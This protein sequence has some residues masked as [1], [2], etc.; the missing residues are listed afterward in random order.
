M[1]NH[2]HKQQLENSRQSGIQKIKSLKSL[3]GLLQ[4]HRGQSFNVIKGNQDL[5]LPL[6]QTNKEV[7]EVFSNLADF[8]DYSQLKEAWKTIYNEWKTLDAE[9][10][11]LEGNICIRLHSELILSLLHLVEDLADLL[12]IH[13][14]IGPLFSILQTSEWVGQARAQ[15]SSMLLSSNQCSVERIR[16]SFLKAKLE[17]SLK[18]IK[19]SSD[20]SNT[21]ENLQYFITIIE[22]QLLSNES[23]TINAKEYFDLASQTIEYFLKQFDLKINH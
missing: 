22:Q 14:E 1:L 13:E 16:M 8:E 6:Q 15:G 9:K 12:Y 23:A 4:R 7:K 5:V 11:N 10:L 21:I 19:Q 2:Y 17:G 18:L 20:D 3:I